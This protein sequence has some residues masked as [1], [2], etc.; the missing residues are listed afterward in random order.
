M[1]RRQLEDGVY[2]RVAGTPIGAV[3]PAGVLAGRTDVVVHPGR[4]A[5]EPQWWTVRLLPSRPPCAGGL[6]SP[7]PT[8][9]ISADVWARVECGIQGSQGSLLCTWPRALTAVLCV[10]GSSVSVLASLSAD[11]L[12]AGIGLSGP[13]LT[14]QIIEGQATATTGVRWTITGGPVVGEDLWLVP[15]P[16]GARAYRITPRAVAAATSIV[17]IQQLDWSQPP[18]AIYTRQVD[19]SLVW[20]TA[21]QAVAARICDAATHLQV[22]ASGIAPGIAPGEFDVTFD[23]L[24]PGIGHAA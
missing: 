24:T 16:P 9:V 3:Y 18:G 1:S 19:P 15:I 22:D 17:A 12:T 7:L 10:Y 23:I 5:P 11:E 8:D 21:P 2:R 6:A 13:D 4:S 14:A 20:S